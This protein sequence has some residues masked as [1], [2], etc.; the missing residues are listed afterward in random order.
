M[1]GMMKPPDERTGSR[2][3]AET[4]SGPFA[5]DR[6]RAARRAACDQLGLGAGAQIAERMGRRDLGEARHL[7]RLVGLGQVGQPAHRERAHRGAVVAA[8]ERDDL[9][10]AGLPAASQYCRAICIERSLASDLLTAN[11]V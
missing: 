2:I 11:I 5:Q 9:V 6:P 10:L 3:T 1:G 4:V 8:L 7:E